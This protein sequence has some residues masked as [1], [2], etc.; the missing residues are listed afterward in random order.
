[1]QTAWETFV[2]TKCTEAS[3]EALQ[4]YD[5]T[6]NAALSGQLP[7]DSDKIRQNHELALE[8]GVTRLETETFGMSAITIEKYLRELTVSILIYICNVYRYG[9]L[10]VILVPFRPVRWVATPGHVADIKL[11]TSWRIKRTRR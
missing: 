8:K 11:G 9:E 7:C 1:M 6:M 10:N 2:V 5:A 3:R 4:I